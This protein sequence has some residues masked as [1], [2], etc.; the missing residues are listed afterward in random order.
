MRK[1]ILCVVA[2]LISR[3][4]YCSPENALEVITR[5]D[6]SLSE[7]VKIVSVEA[8]ADGCPYYRTSAQDGVLTIEASSAVAACKGFY[9]YIRRN[10]LGIRTWSGKRFSDGPLPDEAVVEKRSP[11]QL[12]YYMNVVT[13]GY[14]SA[15]WDWPRWQE[16]IDYMALHGYDMPLA[17]CANEA[18]AIRV[19]RQ[20]GL[21]QEEID[22]FYT[23]PAFLPW[24]RMGN[25]INHDGPLPPSWHEQQ[26]ALQHKILDRLA[27][28][29]MTPILPAFAGFVPRGIQRIYPDVKISELSW[30]G[31]GPNQR[32]WLLSPEDELFVK[33]GNLF[34]QEWEKEFGKGK[35]YLA[36]SFNEMS[37]P[38]DPNDKE[39]KNALLTRYGDA[40]YRSIAQV[41]PDAIWT[42]QGWMFG[43]H[44]QEW[45]PDAVRALGAKVPD[46]KLLFLDLAVNYNVFAW[47]TSFNC[48]FFEGF[49]GKKWIYS[50]IPN[51]GGRSMHTGNMDFFANGHLQVLQSANRGNLVGIGTAPEGI[52][53]NEML[54]EIVAD[55]GWNREE[56]D[57]DDWLEQYAVA[58]FGAY[59]EALRESYSLLRKS[60]Y[61]NF[62]AP[63]SFIWQFRPGRSR[64]GAL[65][66]STYLQAIEKFLEAGESLREQPLYRADA[67]EF[68]AM[69][70][71]VAM[72]SLA[73]QMAGAAN[74]ND[75]EQL[76]RLFTRFQEQAMRMDALL[77]LHPTLRVQRWIDFARAYGETQVLK[78]YYEADARRL[79]TV[80]GPPLTDYARKNWSGMIRDYYLPRWELWYEN[81]LTGESIDYTECENRFVYSTHLSAPLPIEGDYWETCRQWIADGAALIEQNVPEDSNRIA[82]IAARNLTDAENTFE[83][84]CDQSL[85]RSMTGVVF[86]HDQKDAVY[87]ISEIKLILDGTVALQYSKRF[88]VGNGEEKKIIPLDA[89]NT[90]G[91]N[92]S[93]VLSITIRKIS[94]SDGECRISLQQN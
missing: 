84:P 89:T 14:S 94:G 40:I 65:D 78:D 56:M 75:M 29:D 88:Q 90:T 39:A 34:I 22:E 26:I 61:N 53:N 67:L 7:R 31:F 80:W 51:M 77:E 76:S 24:Q 17:L 11:V 28:L 92:N 5:F 59:P 13:F 58:R 60:F 86:S 57:V 85:I 44:R 27:E 43:F 12:H 81:T 25:I 68:S 1:L 52:E 72:E 18:I 63:D 30:A 54:Y 4:V 74:A 73:E 36:D 42:I 47:N 3:H 91:G 87:E 82:A 8:P 32:A 33:I 19:W 48:D 55:G 41:N 2:I 38:V 15:F 49:F 46:D 37:L 35:Y 79:V 16:E 6:P 9:D 83:I 93:C 71:G 21:T 62:N 50:T 23:G 20:L 64:G 69:Y 45:T 70:L 10:G 66:F